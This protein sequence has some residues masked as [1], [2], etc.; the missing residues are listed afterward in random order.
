M[1][2]FGASPRQIIV[3]VVVVLPPFPG[4]C[5]VPWQSRRT[6][7]CMFPGL[8]FH[9][10]M[11]RVC[12]SRY[13]FRMIYVECIARPTSPMFPSAQR[14]LAAHALQRE[15]ERGSWA[16]SARKE[17]SRGDAAQAKLAGN[18]GRGITPATT[19]W[20][21]GGG[22][23]RG[24]SQRRPRP[25]CPGQPGPSTEM[26]LSLS[27]R[28]RRQRR[29]FARSIVADAPWPDATPNN[30]RVNRIDEDSA[31]IDDRR[32]GRN[33]PTTHEDPTAP[34]RH[35]TWRARRAPTSH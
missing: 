17:P 7:C 15:R 2:Y 19:H 1:I 30:K 35:G 33:T 3:V 31:C 29:R 25:R 27:L 16:D 22:G 8:R 11:H 26:A 5:R 13:L 34:N 6:I 23:P 24:P 12:A 20:R 9:Q 18:P 32:R 10:S 14:S 21:G 4:M 28:K